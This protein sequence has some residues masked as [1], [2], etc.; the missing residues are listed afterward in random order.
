MALSR[1]TLFYFFSP[2]EQLDFVPAEQLVFVCAAQ[3]VFVFPEQ[4]VSVFPEQLV[5]TAA[6]FSC[7][8]QPVTV[9]AEADIRPA[10]PTP[11]RIF[12]RSFLFIISP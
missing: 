3:L 6:P 10:M 9:I 5:L 2:A 4:L 12:L 1:P 8:A 11:A 7:V